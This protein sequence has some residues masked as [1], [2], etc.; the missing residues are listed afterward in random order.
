MAGFTTGSPELL[1]AGK[2]LEDTNQ[3]LMAALNSLEQEVEG[4]AGAWSGSAASAF[5]TLM[6]HF[7]DDAKK[8]NT[9]LDQISQAVT[10][11][12]KAYQQQEDESQ[13]SL[14]SII[15]GLSG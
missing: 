10:G 13:Q 6:Q 8:L 15:S 2:Q 7:S 4:V 14:S 5:Q 1:Q 11:N 12:A 9:D 3:Q